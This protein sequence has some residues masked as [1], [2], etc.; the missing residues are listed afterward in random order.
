M[1]DRNNKQASGSLR[2]NG[3]GQPT[4]LEAFA[5]YHEHSA[6]FVLE[7]YG[8]STFALRE[9]TA[10]LMSV[11]EGTEHGVEVERQ[12]EFPLG[13]AFGRVENDEA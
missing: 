1:R 12:R 13:A 11:F 8:T 3:P 10:S 5:Q 2:L 4:G 7:R 9:D 6:M